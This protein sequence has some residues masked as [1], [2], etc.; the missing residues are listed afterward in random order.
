MFIDDNP[1]RLAR[2]IVEAIRL[3][4]TTAATITQARERLRKR[5][6]ARNEPQ[7]RRGPEYVVENLVRP[8]LERFLSREYD[9]PPEHRPFWIASSHYHSGN[10]EHAEEWWRL[11]TMRHRK[12]DTKDKSGSIRRGDL[13]AGTLAGEVVSIELKHLR[14]GRSLD[15]NAC[16][17]QVKQYLKPGNRGAGHD[18]TVLVVYQDRPGRLDPRVLEKKLTAVL[19]RKALAV[20]LE[21][22]PI[23]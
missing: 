6:D 21:G 20:V 14:A 22:P 2:K 4:P 10:D 9:V 23:W 3:I 15:V 7:S 1:R 19:P 8:R 13:F 16:V 17:K 18:A 12:A 5:R 11:F